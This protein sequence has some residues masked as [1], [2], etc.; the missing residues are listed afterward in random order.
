MASRHPAGRGKL[1]A[2]G[3]LSVSSTLRSAADAQRPPWRGGGIA[4]A[5]VPATSPD[6]AAAPHAPGT[7]P[8]SANVGSPPFHDK[9]V[10]QDK[11]GETPAAHQTAAAE[12]AAS[13]HQPQSPPPWRGAG[14]AAAPK[15][16]SP[17]LRESRSPSR[18]VDA[19]FEEGSGRGPTPLPRAVFRPRPLRGKVRCALGFTFAC[20]CRC[21]PRCQVHNKVRIL[22]AVQPNVINQT[23]TNT[24]CC[25]QR[26][27]LQAG[28][29]ALARAL[30]VRSR[31]SL[32]LE[33][34]QRAAADIAAYHL[35]QRLRRQRWLADPGSHS[36]AES[37]SGRPERRAVQYDGPE[38]R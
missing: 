1:I 16:A 6:R 21:F 31:D 25:P 14:V 19:R 15:Q 33:D 4:M 22:S 26:Q 11:A 8:A 7:I 28:A 36:A 2:A 18:V 12:P 20:L 10:G 32:E 9:R 34:E 37:T 3:D 5:Q 29:Q 35:K 27:M 38:R 23:C 30:G 17:P 13:L 24:R